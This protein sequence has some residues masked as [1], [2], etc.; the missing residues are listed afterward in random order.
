MTVGKSRKERRNVNRELQEL[1]E[2][3]ADAIAGKPTDVDIPLQD[4]E[5]QTEDAEMIEEL[6]ID[7]VPERY[8]GKA[9][10]KKKVVKKKKPEFLGLDGKEAEYKRIILLFKGPVQQGRGR[11]SE[12]LVSTQE[13]LRRRRVAEVQAERKAKGLGTWGLSSE[14]AKELYE[15]RKKETGM[16]NPIKKIPEKVT[17]TVEEGEVDEKVNGQLF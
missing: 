1:M 4:L 11:R 15:R 17:E 13:R 6:D 12:E 9:K 10:K 8:R 2:Q 3:A 16:S 14:K 7:V 5:A